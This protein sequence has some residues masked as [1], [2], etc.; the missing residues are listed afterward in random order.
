MVSP[1]VFSL[2]GGFFAIMAGNFLVCSLF[3]AVTGAFLPF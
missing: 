1:N 3:A 2:F